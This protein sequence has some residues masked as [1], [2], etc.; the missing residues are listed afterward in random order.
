MKNSKQER[1]EILKKLI[2]YEEE[3]LLYWSNFVRCGEYIVFR[4]ATSDGKRKAIKYEYDL[5]KPIIDDH[6]RNIEKWRKELDELLA[7]KTTGN[8]QYVPR[9]DKVYYWWKKNK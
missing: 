8:E 7:S 3:R 5:V 2:D 9:D 6:I 4:V 1:S